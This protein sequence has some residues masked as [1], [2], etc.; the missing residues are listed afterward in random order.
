M[1]IRLVD[2]PAHPVRLAFAQHLFEAGSF[3]GESK[4]AHS[5]TAVLDPKNPI[6]VEV[7]KAEEEAAK[8]KWGEK[9]TATLKAIRAAGK[10]VIKDGDL[11]AHYDGFAGNKFI[12]LRSP[13]RPAI[14]G[15]ENEKLPQ[16]DGSIYSG[17][18]AH[19][20]IEVWAM[21]NKFGKRV[22][23]EITGLRSSR[24]GDAFGGGG[25]RPTADDFADLSAADEDM[26]S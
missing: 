20:Y 26:L 2:T 19:I 18:Y 4:P 7:E 6:L 5:V 13:N 24:D 11:K 9:A 22:N 8:A 10:G 16:N 21:D 14:Y 25:T 23:A 1:P 15:R 3:D 12:S 17:S